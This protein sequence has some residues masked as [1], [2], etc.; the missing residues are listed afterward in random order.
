MKKILSILLITIYSMATFGMSVKQLYCCGNLKSISI[1]INIA[2]KE[3]SEKQAKDNGCCKTKYQSFKVKDN[4]IASGGIALTEKQFIHIFN[5]SPA[6]V[7]IV[8][9]HPTSDSSN[10]IHGPP[11]LRDGT[12]LYIFNC[13]FRI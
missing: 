13:V 8:F 12:P 6:F 9:S 11:L 1:A 3:K 2:D 7:S 4:H 5:Y 10:G